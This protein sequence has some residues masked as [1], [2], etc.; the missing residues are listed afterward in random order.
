MKGMINKVSPFSVILVIAALSLAGIASIPLLKVQYA[1][2]DKGRTITVSYVYPDAPPETV[3]NEVTSI[4]EGVL[5][6]IDNTAEITSISSQGSGMVNVEFDRGTNMDA[7]RFEVA[8]AIRNLYSGLPPRVSFPE[9]AFSSSE[10]KSEKAISFLINGPDSPAQ[11]GKYVEEHVLT[12]ISLIEGVD[13]V[14]VN[15]SVPFHWVITFDADKTKMAGVTAGDI[16]NSFSDYNSRQ[17]IGM[18]EYDGG[19]VSVFLQEGSSNDFGSIPIKNIDGHIIYLRDVADWKYEEAAP[20]SYYRVNG[21]NTVTLSVGV[22]SNINLLKTASAVK[23]KMSELQK[24]FPEG[25]TASIGYDSSEYI[26]SELNKILFRTLLCLVILLLFAF[27]LNRSWRYMFLIFITL[28]ANILISIAIYN[29]IGLPI[30][31]YT[32]AGIT[33]SLG[34]IIDTSIVMID[35]YGHYHNRDAFPSVVTAVATTIVALLM[36]FLLPEKERID[37][38]D[39]IKVITVNL[40][41]S[42]AVSYYFV[43][44][45]MSYIPLESRSLND[46][47]KRR[48]R[49]ALWNAG[50]S[51]YIQWGTRR[52]WLY[53]LILI[54][55]FGIP[56]CMLPAASTIDVKKNKTKIEKVIDRVVSWEP[57]SDNKL[58]IDDI[59]GSSFGLFYKSLDR[60]NFYREPEKRVLHIQAGMPEGCTVNQ[61]N[62]IVKKMENFLSGFDEISLFTTS[63]SSFDNAEIK[64]EFK[65]EY[66][67]TLFP[68]LL[69]A[70]VTA[71][72]VDYGGAYWRVSGIDNNYFDNR[73]YAGSQS[74]RIALY[75][76][77]YRNVVDYA[78]TLITH[79]S[80][81][82]HVSTPEIGSMSFGRAATEFNLNYDFA[83]MTAAGINPYKYFGVLSSVLYDEPIGRIMDKGQVS[84]VILQSSD[85][86]RFDLWHI[87]NSPVSSDSITMVLGSIGN[88]VKKRTGTNI[89][90]RNQSYEIDVNYNFIGSYQQS[91]RFIKESV[92][93]MNRNVLPVGYKAEA[94]DSGSFGQNQAGYAWLILLIILLIYVMLAISFESLR[95]PL[96]VIL[97]IPISFI[98]LFLTF[99]LTNFPFDQGGFAALVMLSGIVV[100][101]GIYLV[102]TYQ[103]YGTKKGLKSYLKAFNHKIQPITLTIVSTILGLL[104]FL[105]DGPGEV[106][107][108]DFAIGTI[109]GLVFSVIAL[110]LYL[111]VFV[112]QS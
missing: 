101:A 22:A 47:V 19:Q 73:L 15:G 45:L 95:L 89:V 29:I 54:V 75:G 103:S 100:N 12:P 84:E 77:N 43:P 21:M 5:S 99:G 106:F 64:V 14:E 3:E 74:D 102:D 50:Y 96:A 86:D 2:S 55:I 56:L 92:S 76:Y 16:A 26:A 42:L 9:I 110:L 62:Q 46:S 11:I 20:S 36:V 24:G 7:A 63:V 13:K 79:I 25:L 59:F 94:P 81:N 61:L 87:L 97:M 18:T 71:A 69:K 31:I 4:I 91:E 51:N 40:V 44:A 60:S 93:Y 39:F 10:D 6:G 72:A 32:L 35:H 67:K 98:G 34:I 80:Q 85:R 66:E 17:V 28:T 105:S 30:H 37:L 83:K 108:F 48:R 38:T 53:I 8:S 41:V 1:P 58:V 23:K 33:V 57:Y 90:K 68:N 52:R 104:P 70:K 65:P 78:N 109:G 27:M 82:R 111:P 49:I 107:W 112:N 88:V